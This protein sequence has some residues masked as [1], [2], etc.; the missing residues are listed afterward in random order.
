MNGW[1][2]GR[3]GTS[4]LATLCFTLA[5][6]GGGDANTD[7]ALGDHNLV[8]GGQIAGGPAPVAAGADEASCVAERGRE[9]WL[10]ATFRM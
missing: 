3:T 5:A 7:T 6:C 1:Q 9:V 10:R 4:L 2:M 8:F